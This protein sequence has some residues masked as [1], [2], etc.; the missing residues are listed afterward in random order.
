MSIGAGHL[1]HR[2]LIQQQVIPRDDD[3]VSHTTWVDVAT[4]WAA[5]EPL[6]AR[7]FV[8]SGQTQTAVTARITIRYRAGLQASMRILHR[9]QVYNIAGLLSDKASGLE[10]IT[11][12]VSAG[13]NEGQ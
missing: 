3:G 7:E 5:V 13:V 8:Q 4:V 1:R 9:G 10:Y 2:V 11:I 6:S 12:P